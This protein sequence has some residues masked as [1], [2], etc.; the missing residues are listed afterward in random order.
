MSGALEL[1]GLLAGMAGFDV[2][3]N[4][5]SVSASSPVISLLAPSIDLLIVLAILMTAS[6]A[7]PGA[8]TGVAAVVGIAVAVFFGWMAWRRW[9]SPP[10]AA[11][12]IGLGLSALCAGAA[13]FFLSRLVL[14]AFRSATL[15]NVF[16][17][18][19]ACGAVVQALLGVRVFSASVIP[20]LLG[21]R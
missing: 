18:A 8:R 5:P 13:S 14:R 15:R 12:T 4:I 2:I 1:A 7:R 3:M 20:S 17:L 10:A 16:F 19:A 6:Y 21:F 9:G 11:R